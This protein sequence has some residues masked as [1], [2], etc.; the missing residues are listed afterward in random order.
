MLIKID[1][2][3]FMSIIIGSGIIASDRKFLL[4]S[5]KK[6]LESLLMF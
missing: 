4:K 3:K 2:L 1:V 6:C 5:T